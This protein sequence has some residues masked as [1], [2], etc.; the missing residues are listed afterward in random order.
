MC[1]LRKKL[2]VRDGHSDGQTYKV[3]KRS[4]APINKN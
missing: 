4:Y 1:K 2:A 3:V